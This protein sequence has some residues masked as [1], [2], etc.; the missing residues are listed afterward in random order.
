MKDEMPIEQVIHLVTR[1][2]EKTI[3]PPKEIVKEEVSKF[4]NAMK[5][6][7]DK[8]EINNRDDKDILDYIYQE[9]H[10]NIS[11]FSPSNSDAFWIKREKSKHDYNWYNNFEKNHNN[12]YWDRYRTYLLQ[13]TNMDA[14]SVSSMDKTTSDILNSLG[15]PNDK[16]DFSI[17]GMLLG[18]VQSGKT[19]NIAGIVTKAA[20]SGYNYIVVLTSSNNE[21]RS[22]TQKRID[23][24]FCGYSFNPDK[25]HQKYNVG[26]G[27]YKKTDE[28]LEPSSATNLINDF[29]ITYAE[30]SITI[31]SGS[32]VP[33]LFVMK[34]SKSILENFITWQRSKSHNYKKSILL[35]DDECDYA[36]VNYKDMDRNEDNNPTTINRLI[37][38][39][40]S[41]DV[42]YKS[43]YIAVTA[44]P[45]ANLFIDTQV[46]A[47]EDD[48]K[49]TSL[50]KDIFPEDFIKLTI[51]PSSYLGPADLFDECRYGEEKYPTYFKENYNKNHTE[52][53][54]IIRLLPPVDSLEAFNDWQQDGAIPYG[55]R[56]D[57]IRLL[58]SS[59]KYAVRIFF[60]SNAIHDLNKNN[61]KKHLSMLVN[62]ATINTEHDS[63]DG[64]IYE[65]IYEIKNDLKN[66]GLQNNKES[67]Y[68]EKFKRDYEKEFGYLKHSWKKILK[69][70]VESSKKIKIRTVNGLPDNEI[71]FGEENKDSEPHRVI[72]IGGH[73]LSR[74][75]TIEGLCIT[76]LV[77]RPTAAD[78]L[79]QLG[80]F[81]GYRNSL[82]EYSRV[83]LPEDA[84][85]SFQ[86]ITASLEDLRFRLRRQNLAELTPIQFTVLI[87]NCFGIQLTSN[88]KRRNAFDITIISDLSSKRINY[89]V[90]Y[91]DDL[92]NNENRKVFINFIKKIGI[93]N[94]NQD[95]GFLTSKNNYLWKN[96]DQS[97]IRKLVSSFHIPQHC[98]EIS[99]DFEGKETSVFEEYMKKIWKSDT[100]NLDNWDVSIISTDKNE[101]RDSDLE[102][103]F[104]KKCNEELIINSNKRRQTPQEPVIKLGGNSSNIAS[105]S[106]LLLGLEKKRLFEFDYYDQSIKKQSPRIIKTLNS[107]PRAINRN[108]L[109]EIRKNPAIIFYSI[110]PDTNITKIKKPIIVFAIQLPLTSNKFANLDCVNYSYNGSIG[111]ESDIG[112]TYES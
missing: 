67:S 90:V 9:V 5:G 24:A 53:E 80:R 85:E 45:F 76:Y 48:N 7:L 40:I 91:D 92:K 15:N 78:T 14:S 109:L 77:R 36:S 20:D 46:D 2:L 21:L 106:D 52:N 100:R 57:G 97:S 50:G 104:F 51:S 63:L 33:T 61:L 105:K 13:E 88:P 31:N 8:D 110:I 68:I 71:E 95:D 10:K 41:K 112:A 54:K 83:F 70:M 16:N 65:Y 25:S 101:N 42:F 17:R 22:Q 55:R 79:L 1:Q 98:K 35:I 75:L 81:F 47:V 34:K 93:K 6:L 28:D 11:I 89:H 12:F 44:T 72:I 84:F 62:V 32:K 26:V 49:K 19:S 69:S 27:K 103:K 102:E 86:E 108:E 4:Y 60:L 66:Y 87:K 64:Y 107:S 3:D 94:I 23:E 29:K 39:I 82:R 96:I 74:G 43:S 37:R 18:D 99:R 59:L 73:K 30:S 111:V 38:E 56:E 58:P